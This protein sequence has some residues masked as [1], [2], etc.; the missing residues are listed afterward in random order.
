MTDKQPRFNHMPLTQQSED[1]DIRAARRALNDAIHAL[2]GTTSTTLTR[3]DGTTHTAWGDSL[4][5]QLA[6]AITGAQGTQHG[7]HARS[8]PTVHLTAVQLMQRIDHTV[9]TWQRD[10]G[11]FDGD[12]SREPTPETVRRLHLIEDTTWRPQDTAMITS[13]TGQILAWTERIKAV[14]DPTPLVTLSN[15]CPSCGTAIVYRPDD[16]GDIVRQPALQ[17][18]KDGCECQACHA[19]WSPDRYIFLAKVLGGLPDNVLE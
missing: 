15:P 3:D 4:Y 10:P 18:R 8:L 9:R 11:I 2:V 1:G 14:L 17:I 12:L 19:N 6:D 16:A 13:W 5:D 7:G